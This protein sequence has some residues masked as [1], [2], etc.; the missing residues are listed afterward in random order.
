MLGKGT[1]T[2]LG[3]KCVGPKLHPS[4]KYLVAGKQA[5]N[6]R[7]SSGERELW[8]STCRLSGGALSG[9]EVSRRAVRVTVEG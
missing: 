6:L 8:G 2:G 7:S 3:F 4:K 9:G 1:G 5:R